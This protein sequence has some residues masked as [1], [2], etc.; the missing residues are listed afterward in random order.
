M[1]GECDNSTDRS[2]RRPLESK[3]EVFPAEHSGADEIPE[4]ER[5]EEAH[6]GM[7]TPYSAH[8]CVTSSSKLRRIARNLTGYVAHRPLAFETGYEK[9]ALGISS[10][11]RGVNY[12]AVL[13]SATATSTENA[14]PPTDHFGRWSSTTSYQLACT[15]R[16]WTPLLVALSS[17]WS[18]LS[19]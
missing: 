8:I 10:V 4:G 14:F 19:A 18:R 3:D 1:D 12:A 9:Q 13:T 16:C 7:R 11:L 17:P 2:T 15:A 6:K 5:R